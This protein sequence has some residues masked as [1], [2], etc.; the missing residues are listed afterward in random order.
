MMQGYTRQPETAERLLAS[1]RAAIYAFPQQRL[2][3]II[4]NALTTN[5]VRDTGQFDRVGQRP[6]LFNV[7]DEVLTVALDKYVA[8]HTQ[9]PTTIGA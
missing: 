2:G 7:Y 5:T 9:P 3:Q 1:V 6:D 8:L 4:D